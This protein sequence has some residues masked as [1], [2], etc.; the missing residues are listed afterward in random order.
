MRVVGKKILVKQTLTDTVSKGGIVMAG[1][2]EAL[3]YGEV[4][5]TGADV[6]G[7]RKGDIVLFSAIGA[8]PLGIKKNH[9]LIE[10]EDVLAILDEEDIKNA[11]T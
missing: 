10:F 3:P 9:V 4:V 2:Q 7:T 6:R 11:G 8:I 1:E 5:Q